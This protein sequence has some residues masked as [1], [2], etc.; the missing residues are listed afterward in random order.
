MVQVG[1]DRDASIITNNQRPSLDALRLIGPCRVDTVNPEYWTTRADF[2]SIKARLPAS[3][4]AIFQPGS[5]VRIYQI[6]LKFASG[7]GGSAPVFNTS[8]SRSY[9]LSRKRW[10]VHQDHP[11]PLDH[12]GHHPL[13]P[14]HPSPPDLL[15]LGLQTLLNPPVNSLAP[16]CHCHRHRR[17]LHLPQR[18]MRPDPPSMTRPSRLPSRPIPLPR[19]EII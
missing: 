10:P 9:S 15:P 11:N 13:L 12:P 3:D 19:G 5:P 14:N 2:S 17:L 6:N 8:S 18:D 16:S 4:T 7:S 1:E